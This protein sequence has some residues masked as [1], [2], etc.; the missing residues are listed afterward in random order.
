MGWRSANSGVDWV[1]AA[2]ATGPRIAD[3]LG[4]GMLPNSVLIQSA[5]PP[6]TRQRGGWEQLEQ[7]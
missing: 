5:L 2:E 3:L 6:T 4:F 1:R 7:G